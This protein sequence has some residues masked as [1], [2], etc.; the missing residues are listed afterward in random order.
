MKPILARVVGLLLCGGMLGGFG[1]A[2]AP[3]EPTLEVGLAN[4]RFTQMT[5][6]ETTAL[7]DI[8]VDNLAPE[9]IRVTGGSHR[10][11]VNGIKLGR[12]MTGESMPVPRLGSAV[13]SVEFH[14]RNL[15]LARS[16]H[17]LSQSRLVDYELESTLYVATA[18]G[19]SD[20]TH[21]VRRTGQLDLSSLG[22]GRGLAVLP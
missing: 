14:L 11:T 18:S 7:L 15:S 13:Q 20:R 1:C 22:G 17:E 10:V 8:R 6:F 21:R 4:L 12:G 2:S 9:E 5:V 19:R 16:I 3:D